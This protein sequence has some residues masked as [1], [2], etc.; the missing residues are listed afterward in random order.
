MQP[1]DIWLFR[2]PEVVGDWW[3]Q[4]TSFE[5]KDRESRAKMIGELCREA[6]M[7]ALVFSLLD[8]IFENE[9]QRKLTEGYALVVLLVAVI[10]IVGGIITEEVRKT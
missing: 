2:L 10:L 7:L 4:A 1:P 8:W 5:L 9:A 6:G 3:R